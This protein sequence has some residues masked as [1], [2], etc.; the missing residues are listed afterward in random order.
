VFEFSP[1]YLV[2]AFAP[3]NNVL[4]NRYVNR[5][6]KGVKFTEPVEGVITEAIRFADTP[7]ASRMITSTALWLAPVSTNAFANIGVGGVWPSFWRAVKR[8]ELTPMYRS[9]SGPSGP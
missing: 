8:G 7:S 6:V 1:R 9:I 3:W 5:Y 2:R 4:R